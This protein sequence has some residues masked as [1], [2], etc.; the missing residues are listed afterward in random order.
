M[1]SYPHMFAGLHSS[2]SMSAETAKDMMQ[3]L[4]VD[5]ISEWMM[6]HQCTAHALNVHLMLCC[7]KQACLEGARLV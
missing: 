2:C 1:A 4:T 6:L 3:S 5:S 7:S